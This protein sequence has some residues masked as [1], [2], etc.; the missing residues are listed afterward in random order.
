M[1]ELFSYPITILLCA[2]LLDRVLGEPTRWHPL[3]TFG[4]WVDCCK[5]WFTHPKLHNKIIGNA[6]INNIRTQQ[7]IEAKSMR[8][9]GVLAWLLAVSPVLIVV[10]VLWS[11]LPTIA[12]HLFSI[13]IL[14]FCIGWQSLREHGLA[15]ITPLAAGNIVQAREAVARIVSR[16]TGSLD[17]NAIAK[18]GIESVLENGSDAIFAPIFWFLV[19]GIPGVLLYRLAN[20]LDAMWGYKNEEFLYFGWWAARFDDALNYVPA[21]L[22]ILSYG[23]CGNFIRAIN[24]AK[25]PSA[26]WKS[27]NAG[28]VMAAGAGALEI[29][30]GGKAIYFGQEE[31]RPVLGYL[32]KNEQEKILKVSDLKRAINL[33]DRSVF[34]WCGILVCCAFY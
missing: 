5:T 22:V 18:A 21:K 32:S 8:F 31:M 30:L 11:V 2:L 29:T 15:I 7:N 4:A 26:R 16:D 12:T 13:S 20:T 3:V 6:I 1:L 34:L 9:L 24:S 33:V 17:E 19:L 28:P 23:I 10:S 14:Y 25:R 27:P